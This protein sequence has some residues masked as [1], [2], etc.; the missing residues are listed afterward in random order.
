MVGKVETD[1][2]PQSRAM[3]RSEAQPW[4]HVQPPLLS[5]RSLRR[6][7][8][9]TLV[10]LLQWQHSMAQQVSVVTSPHKCTSYIC[11]VWH[12]S[13]QLMTKCSPFCMAGIESRALRMLGKYH[14]IVFLPRPWIL[15]VSVGKH[16]K[17]NVGWKYFCFHLKCWIPKKF[18]WKR[19]RW[20]NSTH[21]RDDTFSRQLHEEHHMLSTNMW[22]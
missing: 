1:Q 7:K 9:P 21:F 20:I 19:N 8:V 6:I 17:Y 13:I 4:P 14:T 18:K 15:L 3:W 2:K 10:L 12:S 11:K 16:Y 5:G 22:L